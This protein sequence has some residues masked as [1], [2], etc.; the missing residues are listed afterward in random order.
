M[1]YIFAPLQIIFSC[2][3]TNSAPFDPS[4]NSGQT[5]QGDNLFYETINLYFNERETNL[6]S[7]NILTTSG[8]PAILRFERPV[9]FR[10]SAFGGLAFSDESLVIRS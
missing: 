4:V 3:K 7:K 1:Q 5:A 8:N 2:Q 6:S 10:P 9:A